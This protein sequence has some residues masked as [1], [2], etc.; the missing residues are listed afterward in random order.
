MQL[1]VELFDDPWDLGAICAAGV[2]I[3][4]TARMLLRRNEPELPIGM[5]PYFWWLYYFHPRFWRRYRP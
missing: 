2:I 3:I 1:A 4:L 5:R